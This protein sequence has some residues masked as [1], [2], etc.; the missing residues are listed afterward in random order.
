MSQASPETSKVAYQN[1]KS[2]LY[3]CSFNAI[4]DL[5]CIKAIRVFRKDRSSLKEKAVKKGGNTR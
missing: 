2:N 1:S 5:W 4:F 3:L